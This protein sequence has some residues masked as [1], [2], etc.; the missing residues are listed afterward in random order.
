MNY[1]LKN[2]R[3]FDSKGNVSFD[4]SRVEAFILSRSIRGVEQ[5]G[6]NRPFL[7][8]DSSNDSSFSSG[9]RLLTRLVIGLGLLWS[10]IAFIKAS[11]VG[12]GGISDSETLLD[13]YKFHNNLKL[14]NTL[15]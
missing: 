11:S 12:L 6:S 2:E 14:S 9:F 8:S 15:N 7:G 5:T 3:S 4:D 1:W 10:M 13:K